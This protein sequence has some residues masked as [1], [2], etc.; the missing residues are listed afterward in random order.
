MKKNLWLIVMLAFFQ[1][2]NAQLNVS[3]VSNI[4]YSQS[5]NDVWGYVAPDSTEYAL[6]G[7]ATGTSIVSLADPAMPVELAFIPGANST[8]RDIK[9]WGNYA[10]VTC[11][12]GS[13]GLLV[14]DLTN[15]PNSVDSYF[16]TDLPIGTL[17]QC[18]NIY[19]D[20]YGYAYLAGCNLNGGGMIFLD[21]FSDPYYPA[22]AGVAPDTYSHD[23]YV[24]DN[25]MYS[26][27]IFLGRFAIYD[28]SDKDN[29]S[30]L[31]SQQTD[32]SFTHNTWLSDDGNILF[33]TDEQGGAP[34]GSYDVS[35]PS[36]I[37]VLDLF[38]PLETLGDGVIPHNVHV[39]E[40]WL[41]ISYY[42]D[43]CI[44]VD[45]SNPSNLIEVGNFDTYIPPSTGFQGAWGAYPYLPSGLILISDIGNGLY[46]LEPNYVRACWLEGF[47]TDSLNGLPVNNAD[48]LILAS[49]LN[50]GATDVLGEY[51]T[52]IATAGNYDVVF[53][54]PGYHTKTINAV[55]LENGVL[56]NLDVELVPL[57]SYAIS[58]Q[59]V[60]AS[61]GLGIPNAKVF[62]V[63]SINN[64]EL[65]TDSDG[66]FS[67]ASIF[68]DTYEVYAGKW[69][70][71]SNL[72]LMTVSGGPGS[73][74]VELEE[75]YRDE[76]AVDL[77]WTVNGNAQ[78]GMWTI[79][80]PI[81]TT[82]GGGQ[83]ANPEL[84]LDFDLGPR[85][86]MT[87][88]DGGGVGNDDVDDGN[89]VLTSPPMDLTTYNYPVLSYHT[90]FFNGGGNGDP[91]DELTVS[92]SNGTTTVLLQTID[93]TST[94]WQGPFF[95]LLSD[96]IDI[97]NDMT[98]IF[99]TADQ[100]DSGHLVEAAIDLFE[101]REA[102]SYT[103]FSASVMEGC[104][105]LTVNFT[106]N[107]TDATSWSWTF[108]GGT[109]A[110]SDQQNPVV[111]YDAGGV[112]SVS[113][114]VTTGS[115]IAV[116]EQTDLILVEESP[117]AGFT[118][119]VNDATVDF[120]NL[121]TNA[122]SF[123]WDFGDGNTSMEENPTH[124][125][126]ASGEYEVILTVENDCGS[127]MISVNIV[128]ETTGV[129]AI[130]DDFQLEAQPNPFSERLSI[131]YEL[132]MGVGTARL[133]VYNMLGQPLSQKIV[134]AP[135]GT[136]IVDELLFRGV[137]LIQLETDQ[138]KSH[139]LKVIKV[140]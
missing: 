84:D 97:T 98:V 115:G 17:T 45:G 77:G 51:K 34:V 121:S 122:N 28:V 35:D 116:N 94:P 139:P 10:Y 127:E 41:I 32:F 5:L 57:V 43:G 90:W 16:L 138:W 44:L 140:E 27:E 135:T 63:G 13:D 87:G 107:G 89:T 99:E 47:V 105:P 80:D 106:D 7:T 66:N 110:T 42:T 102:D 3:Y 113:L 131:Q 38:K 117:N 65:T 133:M 83:P 23:V 39:W 37:Q 79:G 50:T 60:E 54:A 126:G 82:T 81:G 120:T 69:G 67:L 78:T 70:Y 132:P 20:E 55:N 61:N 112:Y 21:C 129:K 119:D 53:S 4:T 15:L 134:A 46:V 118:F 11:D 12:S 24:R 75:G 108:E 130:S 95:F 88:N 92:V 109:P 93:Q 74:V 64:I 111:T 29:V 124:V 136:I 49:Q 19:I 125:Y 56:T 114:L 59:V 26:S 85:C 96:Y 22:Y 36:D 101:V 52:G 137:Y 72:E 103:N 1:L 91:N 48:V 123:T 25:L 68:E 18:H 40:D 2:A 58:G 9:T 71:Q 100:P 73:V 8:W 33:T 6:V 31:G 128:V 62:L 14:I 76:F 86:Y 30:L 104:T